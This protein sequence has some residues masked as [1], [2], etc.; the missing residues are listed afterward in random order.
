MLVEVRR[1]EQGLDVDL[2][3]EWRALDLDQVDT[4][5]AAVDLAN[6]RRVSIGTQSLTALDLSG[7][8]RLREFINKARE[9]GAEVQ[10]RGP[11]PDQ[12]RLIDELAS[13]L[14]DD[15]PPT[16]SAAWMTEIERRSAEIDAGAVKLD[17][18]P[19]IRQQLFTRL[20]LDRAD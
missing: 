19:D 10:F 7:A 20:G 17:A 14:P 15:Q 2:T 1:T 18:W 11:Q 3:G 4:A 6:A 13:T 12:L 9:A 5:L 16:L 8:W